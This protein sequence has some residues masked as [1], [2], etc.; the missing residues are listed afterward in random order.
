MTTIK[1]TDNIR[2]HSCEVVESC[3]LNILEIIF[4]FFHIFGHIKFLN[5][6]CRFDCIL[7]ATTIPITQIKKIQFVQFY[8]HIMH[9]INGSSSHSHYMYKRGGFEQAK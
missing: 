4:F 5:I 7:I 8:W 2:H 1:F 3:I 6:F 9:V